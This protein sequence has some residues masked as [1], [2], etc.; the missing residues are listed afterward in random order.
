MDKKKTGK[1]IKDAR[2][3]KNYTQSE[4]GDLL[5]VTNK[6]VS[7]WEN[8]ESFPDIGIL[9]S[10]SEILEVKI[11]DIVIGEVRPNDEKAITEVVRFAKIQH[12]AKTKKMFCYT[13]G[14]IALLYCA[15]IGYSGLINMN[16]LFGDTSGGVYI[17][18]L[19]IILI[20]YIYGNVLQIGSAVPKDKRLS[21]WLCCIS[22]FT[23]I[24][25]TSATWIMVV[26]ASKGAIPFGMKASSVGP[27][28]NIQLVA[29]FIINLVI[30]II[31]LYR[32][33]RDSTNIHLGF[34]VSVATLYL[35]ALYGDMLHRL[36]IIEEVYQILLF[37]TA[38]V[39]I[40]TLAALSVTVVI[41]RKG[42]LNTD[43]TLT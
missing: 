34:A 19:T 31:E 9:E 10:L 39:I 2:T 24:W 20:I 15:L 3:T 36:I 38:V 18:S 40:E 8:G 16:I 27:F 28:L 21:K 12:K 43:K 32:I 5:G 37:R 29:A 33:G 26:M 17:I 4:L 25:I 14:I 23:F 42:Q 35:S 30:L 7:R 22:I 13:I 11:Q 1:I 6:A 41:K